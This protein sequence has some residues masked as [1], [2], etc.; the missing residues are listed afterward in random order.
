M[1]IVLPLPAGPLEAT[2]ANLQREITAKEA[3]GREVQRRWIVVQGQLVAAQADNAEQ[4]E[5]VAAQRAQQA[6]L[7]QKRARLEAQ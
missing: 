1:L 3:A 6:V 2:I 5:V 7:Q 4:A